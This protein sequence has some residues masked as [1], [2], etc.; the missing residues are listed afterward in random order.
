M[1]SP[2]IGMV[3]LLFDGVALLG[4]LLPPLPRMGGDSHQYSERVREGLAL[5]MSSSR[6]L[7]YKSAPLPPPQS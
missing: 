3:V 6:F 4:L 1:G 2:Q 7:L 5:D